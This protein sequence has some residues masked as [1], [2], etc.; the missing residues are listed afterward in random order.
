MTWTYDI[1]SGTL[2]DPEGNFAGTG[3]S[4]RA[5]IWRNNP[6]QQHVVAHG[7]I[8]VGRYTIGPAHL[9]P[10]TGPITMNLD[11]LPGTDDFGRSA[12]RM[13]GDNANHDASE[14]CIIMG[15]SIRRQVDASHDRTLTV[16]A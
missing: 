1:S 15:P 2:T 16:K 3:Y 14:G 4:G 8:P 5:G 13:H 6:D 12:F 10:H 9:S 7:P 11:P